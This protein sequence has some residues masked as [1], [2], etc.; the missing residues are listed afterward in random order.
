MLQV[1][2]EKG[3]DLI[4]NKIHY[5]FYIEQTGNEGTKTLHQGTLEECIQELKSWVLSC[6]CK[7]KNILKYCHIDAWRGDKR[8]KEVI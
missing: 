1:V 8:I 3:G 4:M 6:G 7:R 2:K 5:E